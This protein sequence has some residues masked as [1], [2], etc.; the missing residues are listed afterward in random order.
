L[1]E[2]TGWSPKKK[3]RGKKKKKN[4]WPWDVIHVVPSVH[5]R[6]GQTKNK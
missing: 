3:K 2:L 6:H 4:N 5:V 1:E